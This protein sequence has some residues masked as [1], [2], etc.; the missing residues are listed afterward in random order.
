MVSEH[1]ETA[2]RLFDMAVENIGW[3]GEGLSFIT[4]IGMNSTTRAF[5]RVNKENTEVDID[6]TD[7]CDKAD[8]G[9]ITEDKAAAVIGRRI[10]E[11]DGGY[12]GGVKVDRDYIMDNCLTRVLAAER[13]V[14]ILR[15][16]PHEWVC[17]LAETVVVKVPSGDKNDYGYFNVDYEMMERMDI[18]ME[19]LFKAARKNMSDHV[20]FEPLGKAMERISKGEYKWDEDTEDLL[21]VLTND[22]AL[23]GAAMIGCPD[24]LRDCARKLGEEVFIIPSSIHELLFLKKMDG[25]DV[26]A[27]TET[28]IDT[29]RTKVRDDEFLSDKLY[30]IN[31]DGTVYIAS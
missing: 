8:R 4:K 16:C 27:I 13:N 29:N 10:V 2:K 1:M 6:I 26:D 22:D 12:P 25:V 19:E 3:D 11:N 23:F 21:Y 31:D 14:S 15:E 28:I 7:V 18:E 20:V 30:S 9:V 5:V 17:N 24:V